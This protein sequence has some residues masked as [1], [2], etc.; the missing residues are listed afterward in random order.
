M[1]ME[2]PVSCKISLAALALLAFL[3]YK[4]LQ[5]L[6]SSAAVWSYT[7]QSQMIVWKDISD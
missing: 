3:S 6:A 5:F 4:H 7:W 2:L 1:T